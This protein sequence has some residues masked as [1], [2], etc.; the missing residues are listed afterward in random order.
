MNLDAQASTKLL[1]NIIYENNFLS[2]S[3]L[4][5]EVD[6]KMLIDDI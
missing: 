3:S 2:I 6:K 1:Y 5:S 4:T